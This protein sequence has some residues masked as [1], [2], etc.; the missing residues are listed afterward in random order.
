MDQLRWTQDMD[1][2]LSKVDGPLDE[3]LESGKWGEYNH[4]EPEAP[5][6]GSPSSKV[7]SLW[8]YLKHWWKPL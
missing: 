5:I 2:I 8:P 3:M 7:L 4:R 6:P 1:R